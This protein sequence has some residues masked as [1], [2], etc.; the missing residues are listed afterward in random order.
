M[1]RNGSATA[2]QT[3]A[4]VFARLFLSEREK[5][6]QNSMVSVESID[7]NPW[8]P[9]RDFNQKELS[10]LAKS[11]AFDGVLQPLAVAK[12]PENPG[13]FILIAGERR[14]RAAK[15][16]G[17]LEVPV[18][19]REVSS[20]Q[21]LRLALIENTQRSNLNPIDQSL[22]Y[23]N[24]IDVF[25]CSI[26]ECADRVGKDRSTISNSIRLL[27][28]PPLVQKDLKQGLLTVGHA[29]PL[30]SLESQDVMLE[31]AQ[32]V[33]LK[34]LSARQTEA[35]C[36]EIK[37]GKSFCVSSRRSGDFEYLEDSLRAVLKTK[38]AI[39]GNIKQGKIEVHYYNPSELER[40]IEFLGDN[41]D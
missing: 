15:M 24:L 1:K 35:L 23:K 39:K 16:A 18:Y 10:G 31:T 30:L 22:A 26:Q 19:I 32:K 40:I 28:L 21:Q 2:R 34:K 41:K 7:V 6:Q 33:K 25:E 5:D 20:E 3:S 17:L 12:N 38:V 8:Q 29:L 11:I 13:N 36:K 37:K 4:A 14:L 9:R 27:S